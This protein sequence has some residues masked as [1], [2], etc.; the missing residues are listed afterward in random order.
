MA[1]DDWRMSR[2]C[3]G[4]SV[5]MFFPKDRG[6]F[7]RA[8]KVCSHCPVAAEC[9]QYAVCNQIAYG[10][11][12]GTSERERGVLIREHQKIHGVIPTVEMY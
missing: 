10:V 9:L 5:T 2:A 8:K 4:M 12:G 3:K 7:V 11:W 6:Q 1:S